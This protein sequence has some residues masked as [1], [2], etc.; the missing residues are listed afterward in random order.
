MLKR[1]HSATVI[2][3]PQDS[4]IPVARCTNVPA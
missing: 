4:G 2:P 1:A 3:P